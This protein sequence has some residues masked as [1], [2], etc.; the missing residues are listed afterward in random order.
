VDLQNTTSETIAH[1]SGP[2]AQITTTTGDVPEELAYV[3]GDEFELFPD[4]YNHVIT[5]QGDPS[6]GYSATFTFTINQ[7]LLL[8]RYALL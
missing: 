5:V 3:R 2:N 6:G 1:F 7:L 8:P 4:S